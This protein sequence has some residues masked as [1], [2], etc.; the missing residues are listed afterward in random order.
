MKLMLL[1][2]LFP[3]FCVAQNEK[4]AAVFQDSI[5]KTSFYL[6]DGKIVFQKVFT[7]TL[8]AKELSGQLYRLFNT[9]DGLKFNLESTDLDLFGQILQREIRQN[10]TI[11]NAPI[12][13]Q[14]PF[15]AKIVI[16]VKDYKYR[17]TISDLTFRYYAPLPEN[18]VTHPI[19]RSLLDRSGK[20]INDNKSNV[21]L[22]SY[23]EQDLSGLFDLNR[24]ATAGSF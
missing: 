5:P 1:A 17:V 9:T 10:V 12:L 3:V 8:Q 6:N 2:L 4:A 16:Q 21:K 11:F 23:L 20:K 13:L 15:D 24:S 14:I 22:A 7:S 18:D 19:E